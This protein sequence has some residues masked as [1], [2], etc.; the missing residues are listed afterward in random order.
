MRDL[1]GLPRIFCGPEKTSEIELRIKQ[2]SF[3]NTGRSIDENDSKETILKELE[4]EKIETFK[5]LSIPAGGAVA[6]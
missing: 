3:D 1:A 6:P 2:I 5:T 4:S